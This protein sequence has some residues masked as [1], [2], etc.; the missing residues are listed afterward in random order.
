MD[1]TKL[2]RR[3]GDLRSARKWA[4]APASENKQENAKIPKKNT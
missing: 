2:E 1:C 4:P 3:P